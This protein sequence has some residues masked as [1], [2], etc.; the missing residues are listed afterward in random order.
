[1]RKL[2]VLCLLFLCGCTSTYHME[3]WTTDT[4]INFGNTYY[5]DTILVLQQNGEDIYMSKVDSGNSLE[6][7]ELKSDLDICSNVSVSYDNKNVDICDK[8]GKKYNLIIK[9]TRYPY[10]TTCPIYNTRY[11]PTGSHTYG[12]VNAYGYGNYASA[13]GSSNTYTTGF[14]TYDY[15]GSRECQQIYRTVDCVIQDE[16]GKNIAKITGDKNKNRGDSKIS[17]RLAEAQEMC[18]DALK[19]GYYNNKY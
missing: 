6:I 1:M 4:P 5:K 3:Q 14:F 12:T 16:Q 9:I 18:I 15:A 11:V 7:K 17:K 2:L 13:Y 19:K 8:T 10:T